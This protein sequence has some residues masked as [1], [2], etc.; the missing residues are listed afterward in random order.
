MVNTCVNT[1]K[2]GNET[3]HLHPLFMS[4]NKW[5]TLLRQKY[6]QTWGEREGLLSRLHPRPAG[7][8]DFATHGNVICS[9]NIT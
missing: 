7:S 5:V 4:T 8:L 6:E 2:A 9:G 3:L 1:V